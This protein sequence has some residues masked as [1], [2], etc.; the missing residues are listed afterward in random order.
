LAAAWTRRAI[1]VALSSSMQV[2]IV[3]EPGGDHYGPC[4]AALPEF[5]Q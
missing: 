2:F 3:S 1:H 4:R 5:D